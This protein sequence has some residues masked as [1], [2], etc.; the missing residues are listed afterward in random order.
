[1]PIIFFSIPTIRIFEYQLH[2][3]L[4]LIELN[5]RNDKTCPK[6]DWNNFRRI[7][8]AFNKTNKLLT[9]YRVILRILEHQMK[10]YQHQNTK[11]T[12]GNRILVKN[13]LK[14]KQEPQS[15][16]AALTSPTTI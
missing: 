4:S 12:H 14:E 7:H 13:F 6:Q 15:S 1:M 16:S 11:Q 9:R 8:A 3:S 5:S 2:P 10:I